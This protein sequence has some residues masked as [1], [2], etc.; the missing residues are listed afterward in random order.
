MRERKKVPKEITVTAFFRTSNRRAAP[1]ARDRTVL[2]RRLLNSSTH[3]F[4]RAC[5]SKKVPKTLRW[6]L[7]LFSNQADRRAAPRVLR[8]FYSD[9]VLSGFRRLSAAKELKL[10][11]V[12]S[13]E[14][15]IEGLEAERFLIESNRQRAK[16]KAQRL[17]EFKRLKEIEAVFAKERQR[18]H[19]KTAPG[20]KSLSANLRTVS[21]S[22]RA[23][24]KAA[25]SAG[26][27]PRT[28]EKG[29]AVLNKADAGD[30]KAEALMESLDRDEISIDRAYRELNDPKEIEKDDPE[31]EE[32]FTLAALDEAD[33][34][35]NK[36]SR[37]I[38]RYVN[39]GPS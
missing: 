17:R 10:A 6:V 31:Y 14:V 38:S 18:E 22:G 21:N 25:A 39:H 5:K 32:A 15:F 24:E 37:A 19:A 9:Y 12:P 16:T 3:K 35:A 26:L 29:L 36:L 28:A 1:D 7:Q 4:R 30:A 27:K 33:E 11:I 34:A 13:R 23:V 2:K 20:K 8:G